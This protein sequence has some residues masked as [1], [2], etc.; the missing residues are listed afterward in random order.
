[1]AVAYDNGNKAHAF[2]GTG[3][4]TTS[5]FTIASGAVAVIGVFASAALTS[6]AVTV[7]G[8]SATLLTSKEQNVFGYLFGCHNPT[9]GSQTAS[10]SW[11]GTA[12][13]SIAVATFTGANTAS[14]AEAF[15]NA[16]AGTR[17][18]GTGQSVSV[19]SASGDLTVTM[20][21]DEANL[22]TT[23]QT[24]I[25]AAADWGSLDYGPGTGTTTHAWS[26]STAYWCVL[27]VNVAQ[28]AS[29]VSIPHAQ[30]YYRL[31]RG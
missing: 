12:A 5:S 13:V 19:T 25:V 30:H 18:Y 11:T 3:P 28:A 15:T 1:M 31:L 10:V 6:P 20:G 29:G 2:S 4:V 17:S 7:G 16:V 21:F 9:S 14:H 8:Q 24:A 23:D 22:G 27:G 26:G